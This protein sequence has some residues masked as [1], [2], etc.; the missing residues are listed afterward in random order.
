[1]AKIYRIWPL[2]SAFC[3]ITSMAYGA[4]E[5]N[6]PETS[7]NNFLQ[8]FEV[9]GRINLDADHFE[10]IYR[11]DNK[12][13]TQREAELRRARLFIKFS[14]DDN[15]SS[16][17]QIAINENDDK[18]Q[19]K[20]AYIRYKGFDF[21]DI[22]IGQIKEP[23]GLENATS[24]ASA[25][26]IERSP[27]SSFALGRSKGIN[28]A[29]SAR[30]YSWNLGAYKVE[31]N[32]NIKADGDNAYTARATFSPIN[33]D[34]NYHHYGLTYSKR[35]LL[36]AEYELKSNGGINSA[37]NFLDTRNIASNSIEQSGIEGAWGR[38]ALSF[39]TEYQ[40]LKINAVDSEEDASYQ[41]HYAQLSYFLTQD[42]RPYKKG[43]FASVK[44]LS[45]SGAWELALRYGTLQSINIGNS[46][47][48]ATIEVVS[49]TLGINYYLNRRIKIMLNATDSDTTG[50][51]EEGE[52]STGK[53][54]SMRIQLRL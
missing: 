9:G 54:L 19:L 28:F 20:D 15:W 50:I 8:K 47:K 18:Y 4:T 26:F 52:A 40:H 34:N 24:S 32:S 31:E 25:T 39:Q 45:S 33:Q 51:V 12:N 22:K 29:N 5:S 23:F 36:G 38:G 16:K 21:A 35:K 17:L 2:V 53:S 7:S 37:F 44:P 48:N 11:Q 49:S 6:L 41:A 1:M 13:V 10:G 14:L 27:A 30:N 42:H 3:A 43:R 46:D